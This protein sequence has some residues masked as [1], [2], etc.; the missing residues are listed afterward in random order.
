MT[1][2]LGSGRRGRVA[3]RRWACAGAAASTGQRRRMTWTQCLRRGAAPLLAVV[4]LGAAARELPL[5]EAVKAG[6]AE[7]V[8]ALLDQRVDVNAAEVDGA[9]ALHWAVRGEEASVVGMLLA[10]GADGTVA[11]RYGV[12]PLSLACLTGNAGIITQLLEAGAD[13][14][15][16]TVGGQTA[17]MTAART[18]DV[19]AVRVLLAHGADVH[20]RDDTHG[21]TALMWAAAENNAGVVDTLVQAGADVHTRTAH[22]FTA[23]LFAA[24]ARRIA[25]A[26]VLLAAGA[27]VNAS[28]PNGVAPLLLAISNLNY[29]LAAILLRAGADA[30]V[31]AVGW[32]TLHQLSWSRRPTLGYNNPERGAPGQRQRARSRPAAVGRR[33]EPERSHPE[34][35]AGRPEA[36]QH[37]GHGRDAV[38]S[39]GPDGRCRPDA[40]PPGV[41]GRSVPANRRLPDAADGRRRRWRL[42]R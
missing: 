23:F 31:D 12:T 6:S 19:A 24:R 25:A 21:Q 20:A 26:Q 34:R 30:T 28:L 32:S 36:T 7:S 4:C 35:H 1:G 33:R 37:Q 14:N 22:G 2:H 39:R 29:E 40:P 38:L 10:A 17:L 11:N 3:G 13:A 41:R 15:G 8:R 27:D 42:S 18:G 5:V 16:A 9:T